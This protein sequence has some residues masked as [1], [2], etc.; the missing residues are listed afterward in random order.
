MNSGFLKAEAVSPRVTVG[1]V[2]QN[3]KQALA[4]LANAR[5]R[6]VGLLVFP[7]LYL[8]AYTCGD[9]FLQQ[10][11]LDACEDALSELTAA[12]ADSEIVVCIGLPLL[13][14]GRLYNCAAVLQ[15]GAVLAVIP[16]TYLPNYNEYYEKRWFAS[17]DGV[18]GEL[19]LHGQSVPFG[20][21]LIRLSDTVTLG[22]ELCEDLW[23]PNAPS[24]ALC[25]AGANVIANLSA[26]NEAVTKDAYRKNLIAMQSAKA[27]CAYVYASAGVGES[28][29]D[30]V[31]SG[32]CTIAENGAL[33]AE[34]E[35]FAFDGSRAAADIDLDRLASERRRDGSF[36]DC[37]AHAPV[38]PAVCARVPLPST[39]PEF[40]ERVFPKYPF[41]P[42]DEREKDARC[43]EILSIQSHALAKRMAH[44]GAKCA[45]VGISG[46]LDSTLTLLVCARSLQILGLPAERLLCVTMPGFGT[47]DRTYN[48]ACALV[49]AF[50]AQLLEIPIREAAMQHMRDIGHDP[51]VRD[52]TYENTQARERTQI[53]MD[54]AN[55]HGGLLVGTGDLSELALGW[56]TYNADHMSMYGVNC[57]VPK[58]LVRHLVENEAEHL[59]AH[60]AAILRDILETPVSPEL[61]PPDE[62]G[63]IQQKTEETLGP[64]A[65]HD[66]FLYHF[67]RFGTRPQKLLFLAARTFREYTPEQLE[68][69]LRLFL[70]RFF[71]NQ[72]KRSCLPD[73]PKV[74]SVSLS[75]RGDWRM[76]SDADCAE[77]L[78]F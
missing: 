7:E 31:F 32:A 76:P 72:F 69:W 5:A 6:H 40:V 55:K 63:N 70:R 21:T 26:S 52:V 29:T 25:L 8:S 23:V 19:C 53:L 10:T 65:V 12:T 44:T 77:W 39:P 66:F 57:G 46:G 13:Y 14:R 24:T 36:G 51:A 48:N 27:F 58:T 56:C 18:R 17:G 38:L 37:A 22:V 78:D 67:L 16:K 34:G 43:R 1:G 50:G 30:L 35:R 45:V 60:A 74:G 59:P 11:L 33:L 42:A 49:Q 64:Y 71:S 61:L 20:Q 15:N 3:L 9:L 47:T 54:L 73:G 2:R 28:T 68:A 62:Q 4:A 41:V 75:P